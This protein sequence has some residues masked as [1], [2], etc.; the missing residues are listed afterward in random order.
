[1]T[2]N[3]L[4]SKDPLKIILELAWVVPEIHCYVLVQLLRIWFVGHHFFLIIMYEGR[5][6]SL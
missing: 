5:N 1:M 3:S 6:A 2:K 4:G